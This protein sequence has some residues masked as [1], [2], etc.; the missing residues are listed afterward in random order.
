MLKDNFLRNHNYLR[1]SVTDKCNLRCRYCMPPD[2]IDW[3]PHD[4]VLRNEEFVR[5]ISVFTELG[6]KK[7]RFTGGEPLIRKGLL[8]IIEQ[9]RQDAPELDL[10]L[11]TNGTL[12]ENYIPH[13]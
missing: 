7:V 13:L 10:C 3:M 9:I 8:D 12:L 5:L 2:G 6:I 11:T 1:V 4:M